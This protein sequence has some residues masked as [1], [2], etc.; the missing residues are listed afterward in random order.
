M[1]SYI[2]WCV[3]N[4][5]W[6]LGQC[7]VFVVCWVLNICAIEVITFYYKNAIVNQEKKCVYK[8]AERDSIQNNYENTIIFV[9]VD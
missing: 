5:H 1:T 3:A 9:Q 6:R 4:R 2:Y 8:V 7:S